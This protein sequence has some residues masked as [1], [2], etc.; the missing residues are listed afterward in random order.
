MYSTVFKS[1][2]LDPAR[3]DRY[4]M[5][6]LRPGGSRDELESLEVKE[7]IPSIDIETQ[8]FLGI[9]RT[10]PK[11]GRIYEGNIWEF[12]NKEN[13]LIILHRYT[14]QLVG[15]KKFRCFSTRKQRCHMT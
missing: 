1:D 2:P 15:D 11:F 5:S 12:I 13:S 8:W 9:P 7:M 6:I 4:R 10:P 3:G 14:V